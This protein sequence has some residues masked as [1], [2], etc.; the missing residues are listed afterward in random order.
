MKKLPI[1]IIHYI[2]QYIDNIDIRR[3]FGIYM[4][5]HTKYISKIIDKCLWNQYTIKHTIQNSKN[6]YSCMIYNLP[7]YCPRNTT[8]D[9]IELDLVIYETQITYYFSIFRRF[10]Q[11]DKY[12]LLQYRYNRN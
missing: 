9:Y 6:N 4:P 12:T 3:H 5:I 7:N 1:E 10:P 8:H 11:K 2:L